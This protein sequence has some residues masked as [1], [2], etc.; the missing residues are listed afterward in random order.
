MTSM[1]IAED[2]AP[3]LSALDRPNSYFG[4]CHTVE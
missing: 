4:Y 1:R 2:S 3:V